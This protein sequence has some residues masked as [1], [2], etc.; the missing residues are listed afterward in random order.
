MWPHLSFKVIHKRKE[1][2]FIFYQAT[3]HLTNLWCHVI[4]RKKKDVYSQKNAYFF[5]IINSIW[6]WFHCELDTMIK[7]HIQVRSSKRHPVC[8]PVKNVNKY[9]C[10]QTADTIFL[11][12]HFHYFQK[13]C[14]CL[15]HCKTM[16]GILRIFCHSDFTWNQFC[17]M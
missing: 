3:P 8:H 1:K 14:L 4:P 6:P 15:R 12:E 17:R 11:V 16:C 5:H 9:F 13:C 2:W 7:V 10:K